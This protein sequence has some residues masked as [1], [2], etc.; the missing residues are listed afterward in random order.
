MNLV[1]DQ[2]TPHRLRRVNYTLTS[3]QPEALFLDVDGVLIDSLLVKGEALAE[4]FQDFPDSRQLAID[5]HL[6]NGGVT[7]STK[8]ARL[9]HLLTGT[10]APKREI[11]ER[12]SKFSET[13]RQ[14]VISAREIPGALAALRWWAPRCPLYAVSATPREELRIILEARDIGHHFSGIYGWPPSK[15][16]VISG[17]LDAHGY[18]ATQCVLIGDTNEDLIASRLTDVRFVHVRAQDMEFLPGTHPTITDLHGL[19]DA[20]TTV[21]CNPTI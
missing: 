12:C 9:Y 2:Q 20:I 14:Q 10:E 17:L 6:A 8:I 7:R 3:T 1:P 15:G 18:T 11:Q 4:T 21:L 16:G 19:N 5:F 13:V